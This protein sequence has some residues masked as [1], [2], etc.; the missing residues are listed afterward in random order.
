VDSAFR[1]RE[2]ETERER[3]RERATERE[4]SRPDIPILE[5]SGLLGD[6]G[7]ARELLLRI[8]F[9]NF[10]AVVIAWARGRPPLDC[11][12]SDIDVFELTAGAGQETDCD[13]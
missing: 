4:G 2:S 7:G 5:D 10:S 3:E 1:G 11:N 12:G 13:K 9:K 8:F 6:D